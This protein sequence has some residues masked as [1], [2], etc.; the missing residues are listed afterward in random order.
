[1]YVNLLLKY[2]VT[3][4]ITLLDPKMLQW[5]SRSHVAMVTMSNHRNFMTHR[6]NLAGSLA[7]FNAVITPQTL[8]CECNHWSSRSMK[9]KTII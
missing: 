5:L 8:Q 6:T 9:N 3:K 1:M 2:N 4:I 7:H